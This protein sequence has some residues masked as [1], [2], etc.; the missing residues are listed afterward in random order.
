MNQVNP[1]DAFARHQRTIYRYMVKMTGRRELAEDPTQDV[2][3]RVVRLRDRAYPI[4]NERAWLF[5]IA[6]NLVIDHFRSRQREVSVVNHT[7]DPARAAGQTLV[8]GLNQALA[9]LSDADREM[10]VLKELGGLS[11]QEIGEICDCTVEAVRSRL[12]RT[13]LALR[14]E[15]SL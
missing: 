2:Y 5:T 11:Y 15:L 7:V 1:A 8:Y 12:H 4:E 10:F 6:R 14:A 9:R 13:R 3:L